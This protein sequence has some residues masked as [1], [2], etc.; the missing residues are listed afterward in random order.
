MDKTIENLQS[1]TF[2]GRRFTRKQIQEIQKTVRMFSNLSY[3]ELANT[4]CEHLNW[5]TPTGENRIQTCIGVLKELEKLGVIKLP[6]KDKNK[7][8][9]KRKKITLTE[10][11]N[12][13]A[14]LNC[15]LDDLMPIT[16]Q[17]AKE[18]EQKQSWNEYVERYH[19]LGYKQP[20]GPHL[21]YFIVDRLG[22]K[23]GCMLFSF[24]T[25][26]LPSRDQ[27][28]GWDKKA[29]EKNLKLV[30]NNNRFLIFPWVNVKNLASK[31]LSM[32][33]NQIGEDW[34]DNHGYQ[35]VLLETFVDPTK[36]KGTCYKAA[37]WQNIGK[38]AGR[39]QSKTLESK[40]QKDIYVYPLT[41]NF[42]TVL[43]SS[44]NKTL[45]S[46]PLSLKTKNKQIDL[47]SNDPFI[48]LWQKIICIVNTVSDDFDKQWQKRKRIL[49][50]MM[51]IL[52]VFRLV[53]SKNKQGYA[54]TI[55]ELWDQCRVMNIQLP[56]QKPVAASAFCNA[57]KKLDEDIFKVLHKK[58]INTYEETDRKYHWKNHRIFAV[59][60]SK[61][62]L[63]RQLKAVGYNLPSEKSYYPQGLVSCLYQLKSK[64]P[65]DFDLVSHKN[66]RTAALAHLNILK[67]N[68]VV[69]YDR[70]YFSYAMLYAHVKREIH[71]VFRIQ[72]KTFNVVD[73]IASKYIIPGKTSDGAMMFIPAEAIFAD[74]HSYFADLVEKAYRNRVWLVSPTTMMAVLTTA[75]AVLKDTETRKQ[76][77]II[78]EHL[79][80]LSKDFD[81]FQK[82]MENLA[83][84]IGQANQD[85]EQIQKSAVKITTRFNKIEKVEL[86]DDVK[87]LTEM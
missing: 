59:D 54:I 2:S 55:N 4:I 14:P 39:K 33:T 42:R 34:Q 13:Q 58:I 40:S 7:K 75:R 10:K 36:Y 78:Q 35:P 44:K 74:I 51:V 49:N 87:S 83:R 26:S 70:G 27:W 17:I 19:Y 56:Q 38:S 15:S 16:L 41:R 28:I 66:E 48:Q 37:N 3:S 29:N 71:A 12:S 30:V 67:K 61:L 45:V 20:I 81:R 80:M 63:P 77:H 86:E 85:V 21:R 52:F 60:G 24:P 47:S 18:K 1:T 84:H 65:I 8:S 32:V 5:F 25:W 43:V 50:S 31:S 79:S 68:D 22:R 76:V 69:V 23:L 73:D 72:N 53:F 64:M 9:G 46:K 57:R 62:N 11:T 82:H 6:E